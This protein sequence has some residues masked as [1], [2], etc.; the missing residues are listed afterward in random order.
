MNNFVLT[1]VE[2]YRTIADEAYRKMVQGVETI[3]SKG[4]PL[5]LSGGVGPGVG[6]L[7]NARGISNPPRNVAIDF[8]MSLG[9]DNLKHH[10]RGIQYH[11]IQL[12]RGY[13]TENEGGNI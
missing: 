2:V 3:R 9:G 6:T 11:P 4:M 1:N 12:G 10:R 8:L 13:R 5:G 7:D